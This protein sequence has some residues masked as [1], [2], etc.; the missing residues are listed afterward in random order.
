LIS[1]LEVLDESEAV[2]VSEKVLTL[3]QHFSDRGSVPGCFFTLGAAAYLDASK[4][5]LDAYDRRREE[6]N[7]ILSAHFAP[8][9]AS[10]KS[11]LENALQAEAYFDPA[12]AL[13]GFH[14]WFHPGIFVKPNASVHFDL[15]HRYVQWPERPLA[16][17]AE[18]LSFTLP[19]RLPHAGGGLN[20]WDISYEDY[21]SVSA[22]GHAAGDIRELPRYARIPMVYFP[23][24][25]G[26]LVLQRGRQLHQIAPVER[27]EPTDQRI[28]LQ[29][30]G[31]RCN[32]RWLLYW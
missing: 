29:G 16:D 23:Y 25:V 4:A 6:K 9:Y 14:L 12:L 31:V 21:L 3:R 7:P 19:L 18:V 17:F 22:A 15:Q 28:T 32:D 27:V 24:T 20:T 10:L 1:Y 8:L 30:H 2:A 11:A 5:S 13:P 26:S